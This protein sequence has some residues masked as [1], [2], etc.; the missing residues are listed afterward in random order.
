[1]GLILLDTNILA[2]H[3]NGFKEAFVE[4]SYHRNVGISSITYLE[5]AVGLHGTNIAAFDLLIGSLPIA[6]FHTDDS[7]INEAISIRKTSI[8]VYHA[9]IGRKVRTADS[10]I[11]ATAN[12]TG[13]QLITRNPR[14]FR[15]AN[16]PVR[17]PYQMTNGIVSNVLPPP[18]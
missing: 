3:F 14:D 9:G 18:P 8:A 5:V 10:I 2:D 1:M 15:G 11:L 17:V 7:I 4:I 12:V 6:I 13:R 16:I